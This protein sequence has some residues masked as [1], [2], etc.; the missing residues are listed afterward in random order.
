MKER[1]GLREGKGK[2]NGREGQ[3]EEEEKLANKKR[4]CLEQEGR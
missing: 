3:K 2:P 4:E 1:K